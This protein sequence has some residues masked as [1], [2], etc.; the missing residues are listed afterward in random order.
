[1]GSDKAKLSWKFYW[2]SLSFG[3]CDCAEIAH[4]HFGFNAPTIIGYWSKPGG[5][6]QFY[7]RILGFGFYVTEEAV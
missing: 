7:F 4:S 6:G 1:M 3:Y 2:P 5:G